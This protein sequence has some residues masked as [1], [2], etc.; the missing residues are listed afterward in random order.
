MSQVEAKKVGPF[1]RARRRVSTRVES[2]LVPQVERSSSI[3]T[4]C[5]CNTKYTFARGGRVVHHSIAHCLPIPIRI[6]DSLL[7][8]THTLY[9]SDPNVTYVLKANSG[10]YL[11]SKGNVIGDVSPLN[12]ILKSRK[13]NTMLKGLL[14]KSILG[15]RLPTTLRRTF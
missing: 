12:F 6:N 7:T 10:S 5:F 2:G 11:C 1:F 13:D 15:G 14:I 3:K 9:K 4:I 8:T